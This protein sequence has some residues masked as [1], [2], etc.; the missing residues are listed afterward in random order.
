MLRNESGSVLERNDT[1][2][3]DM[4]KRTNRAMYTFVVEV[5]EG[6]NYLAINSYAKAKWLWDGNGLDIAPTLSAGAA[7]E[8]EITDQPAQ[9]QPAVDRPAQ[10]ETTVEQPVEEQPAEIDETLP[11][12]A[13]G[14][15]GIGLNN[16]SAISLLADV[17]A[18]KT[19]MT[20]SPEELF[21]TNGKTFEV[22]FA[23]DRS[24]PVWG[25]LA[26]VNYDTDL[27]ELAGYEVG[28]VFTESQFTFQEDTGVAPYKFLATL[29]TLD[30][31]YAKDAVITLQFK[32]K[33][34]AADKDTTVSLEMLEVVNKDSQVNVEKGKA[35]SLSV[36]NTAPQVE[37]IKDG[38]TYSGDTTV[39]VKEA[40]LTSVTVNG[41]EVQ[42]TDGKFVL[43]PADGKQTVVLTDACGHTTTLT[44]TVKPA[45][46]SDEIVDNIIS[47]ISPASG[48]GGSQ[49][50]VAV[51]ALSLLGAC[52][53]L[54]RK[55]RR[56]TDE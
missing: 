52:L 23:L 4:S 28:G 36:D 33:D 46:T 37:G 2:V 18:Q 9:E 39:T 42:L 43:Y 44:V 20:I 31:T 8:N 50:L 48:D 29:D 6:T 5:A 51:L 16:T 30:T 15:A 27:L 26:A 54:C 34:K 7:D 12:G 49:W 13:A 3:F 40:H 38:G 47:A 45:P 32:V 10:E 1:G 17:N 25:V 21:L 41:K 24:I 56:D 22:S 19:T 11:T 55:K 53:P 14:S 35:M